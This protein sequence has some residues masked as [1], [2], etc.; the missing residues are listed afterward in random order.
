MREGREKTGRGTTSARDEAASTADGLGAVDPDGAPRAQPLAESSPPTAAAAAADDDEEIVTAPN[1]E[2]TR[3]RLK[4]ADR[5]TKHIMP[6]W[7]GEPK[8]PRKTLFYAIIRAFILFRMFPA[9]NSQ[10]DIPS[11]IH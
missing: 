11:I 5:D 3:E 1:Q 8:K 9:A 10:Y 4:Q 6:L 7:Y 2:D